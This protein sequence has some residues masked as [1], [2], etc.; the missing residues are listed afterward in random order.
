MSRLKLRCSVSSKNKNRKYTYLSIFLA[1]GHQTDLILD[2]Q[3]F[4]F[5]FAR[6]IFDI[7]KYSLQYLKL[8]SFIFL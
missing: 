4:F 1:N 7:P 6:H 8:A 2:L 5:L 3:D